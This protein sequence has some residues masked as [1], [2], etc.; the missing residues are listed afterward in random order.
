MFYLDISREQL[1]Y[2]NYLVMQSLYFHP[3]SNIWDKK[4]SFNEEYNST[5]WTKKRKFDF[6]NRIVGTL[7]EVVFADYY[8]LPRPTRSFGA[9]DGQDYGQDFKMRYIMNNRVYSAIIDLKTMR[10]NNLN[11]K[12][13]YVQNIPKSNI[14]RIDGLNGYYFSLVIDFPSNIENV[15][16]F[17]NN[18]STLREY[19]Q[20]Y[21][22]LFVGFVTKRI[23]YKYGTLYKEG[24]IRTNDFGNSFEF[25]TDTYEIPFK[26]FI[27]PW[28]FK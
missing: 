13:H 27:K 1:E 4:V 15:F 12:S 18:T 22:A 25:S 16:L 9:I 21:K 2:A 26:Y 14:D 10:R 19:Q 3:V 7:G 5:F 8:R 11:I 20:N 6:K 17:E 28:M 24:T 23:I